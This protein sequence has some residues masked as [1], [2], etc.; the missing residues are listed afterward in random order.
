MFEATF[1]RGLELQGPLKEA[2]RGAGFDPDRLEV[3][4]PAALF[5]QCLDLARAHLYPALPE[6][7]GHWEL[8]RAFAKGFQQT[9]IGR[10]ISVAIP[11]LG[12]AGYLKRF[13]SHMKMSEAKGLSVVQAGPKSFRMEFRK[14][15]VVPGFLAGVLESGVK[16]TRVEP[17]V[18]LKKLEPGS[19]D[20]LIDW[21]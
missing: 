4:Y 13:P 12:P 18:V 10:I 1:V 21:D 8:G 19:F 9:M 2:L 16:A 3:A 6:D 20:I 11:L 7:A 17:R 5:R 15:P 14:T